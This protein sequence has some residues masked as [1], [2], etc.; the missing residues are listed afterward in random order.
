MG[1]DADGATSGVASCWVRVA[2][3]SAGAAMGM[4]FLPRVGQEVL[5]QFLGNDI[6]RPIITGALYNG[7]GQGGV[8]PTPGGEPAK[9]GQQ[10]QE[11]NRQEPNN[12]FSQ[13][14]DHRP[15]AQGN[16]IAGSRSGASG[17]SPAWF[18][19]A[20]GRHGESEESAAQGGHANAAAQ[21]GIRTQEWGGQGAGGGGGAGAKQQVL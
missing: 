19:S 18:G 3:R 10:S 11:H 7:Q 16:R 15:S 14:T 2:Q 20:H 6:D 4:Q 12:P 5:V 9:V 21:W 17:N 1:G 13:S 8:S